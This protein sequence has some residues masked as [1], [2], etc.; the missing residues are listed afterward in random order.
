[1]SCAIFITVNRNKINI[2]VLL[3]FL[4]FVLYI[5]FNFSINASSGLFIV[6]GFVLNF[7]T[8][9]VA[10]ST[11]KNIDSFNS[12]VLYYTFGLSI[13]GI[14]AM[15]GE[16]IPQIKL[17]IQSMG[18]S[19]TVYQNDHLYMRFS[20][21][22]IDPNYFAFQVLFGISLLIVISGYKKDIL[23]KTF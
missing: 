4:F 18:E 19:F 8:I 12:Y 14:V 7:F 10:F 20:G 6:L 17:H 1:M 22:D 13:S 3:G 16:F 23:K 11:I 5:L 21:L 2:K 15:L 9:T